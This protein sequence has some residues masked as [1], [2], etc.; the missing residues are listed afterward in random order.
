MNIKGKIV[1]L[2]G[3][4]Q[5]MKRAEASSKLTK[6]GAKVTDSVSAKTEVLFAGRAAGSKL[7]KAKA[8]GIQILDEE[9]LIA[10]LNGK[11]LPGAAPAAAP[12]KAAA[13]KPAAKTD[14]AKGEEAT[15][16]AALA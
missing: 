1:V 5:R 16:F 4:F 12:A 8:L 11:P 15:G 9:A 6:M 10:V 2:T 3:E 7:D 14:P 13:K